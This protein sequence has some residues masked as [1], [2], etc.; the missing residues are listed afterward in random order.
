MTGPTVYPT[1]TLDRSAAAWEDYLYR[2]TPIT[3]GAGMRY[4]R[5]DAFAPL[6]YGGPNGS[7]LRQ[8]VW[9]I[10]RAAADGA[11]GVVTG[12]SV[13]SPQTSMTALVARHYGLPTTVILGGTKPHT[14]VRHPNVA[15]AA[16]A[17]ADLRIIPVGYNPAIQRAVQDFA[18][19]HPGWYTVN[20]GIT[21]PRGAGDADVAA[22][23]DVGAAQVRNLP[24]S[25]RTLV[26]TCGSAN[27]CASV[28]AG[29]ARYRP[30]G[31]GRVV[32]IGIGPNRLR[33]LHE[34]L[35]QI[36]AASGLEILPLFR[37]VY[38]HDATLAEEQNRDCGGFDGLLTLEHYD[39]HT[40]GFVSYGDRRPWEQDGIR[41]H[42]TY[43]GK[44]FHYFAAHPGRF[45]Y[46]D[47]PSTLFWIVG[48]EPSPAVVERFL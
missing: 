23:H 31:L 25:V 22:F 27:S 38:H 44:A 46:L 29:I 33:W 3:D 6:G 40:T 15:I 14:A 35:A 5:E 4:K 13:L 2:D 36:E 34:R 37:R 7:K 24:S 47:D 45:D 26:M 1:P 16:R 43:E 17:G 11:T 39:L 28:L 21:T 32:L 41:F 19:E 10:E 48:S 9:L 18:A 12:A 42:P 30:A 20:Y 8:L